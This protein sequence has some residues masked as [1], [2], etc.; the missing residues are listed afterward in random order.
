MKTLRIGVDIG[1]TFT[2]IV[3][4]R[5]DGVLHAIKVASTPEDVGE[6]VIAGLNQMLLSI[7]ASMADVTEIVHGTTIGSNTILQKTGARTGVLT[8]K[9]FR[10]ILE[11]ARIRTPVM[12]DL[13]W[14]KPVPLSPRR[15]RLEVT[16]R[17][18]A[19][20]KIVTPL[21][22]E[23][24][25]VAGRKFV[26]DGVETVAICFL[27]SY[28]NSAHEHRAMAILNDEFS[29]LM[30]T[31]SCEVLPE[32]KE[33]ERTS[34]TVVNAYLLKEMRRYLDRL[35]V[36]LMA[37]GLTAPLRVMT[38]LGGMVTVA[39]AADKPVFA[40]GSGPAG[41]AIGSAKIAKIRSLSDAIAFDLG[42][43]TAKASLIKDGLPAITTEYEFRDGISTPSRFVKG[44]GYMLKVPTIDIAEV[45][46]GGGSIAWIDSGGLLRVGPHSAGAA[47][48]P[49]CYNLGNDKPTVTD[50]NICLGYLNPAGFA[51]GSLSI[52]PE[53]S[54][55][56]IEKHIAKPLG[57]SLA[58]AAVGIRQIANSEMA[59]A[60]RAVTVERGRDPRT[61]T[62]IVSGGGGPVHAAEVAKM[63]E[64]RRIVVTPISGVFCSLGMLAAN[65]SY[66]D[67]QT[68]LKPLSVLGREELA[69]VA[70]NLREKA[71]Q[72]MR[73]EGFSDKQITY[74]ITLDGRYIGQSSEVTIPYAS[75][76]PAEQIRIDF[77]S[78]YAQMY[79]HH[80]DEPVEIVNLR[81]IARG[82]S[83]NLL[84][85]DALSIT[86][87]IV[88]E[89]PPTRQ[90]YFQSF[91]GFA[92]TLI[93]QR[94]A[95]K[96]GEQV[97][98]PAIIDAYDTTMVVPPDAQAHLDTTQSVIIDI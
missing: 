81:L 44:G 91:G 79:G 52:R 24:V 50:A 28:Q 49:A 32:M 53:L 82:D 76:K 74:E 34:T 2:D 88:A 66:S 20:G 47:P 90:A 59:R 70:D 87:E 54:A 61:M 9:G 41:G 96:L 67:V 58:D 64:I 3:A 57:L 71:A 86:D 19:E 73:A 98:G 68:V 92:Q 55:K 17:I 13:S 77:M 33:Y 62:L 11:I 37:A 25:R 35:M 26:A 29:D 43:T 8:T 63:L 27:H 7:G 46:A 40:V 16:E 5:G 22:E 12:F 4:Q 45:G 97:V 31:V 23:D 36:R 60:I 78:I 80:T 48:G 14:T 83:G 30:V 51:G 21:N 6:A 89:S 42:G 15:W 39:V 84:K 1:G 95:M 10:D 93:F 75:G 72:Q 56:A 85:F 18:D 65:A 69:A 38:S 94:A